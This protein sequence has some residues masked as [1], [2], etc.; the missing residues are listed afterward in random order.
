M[1]DI[2][3]N[4]E[5]AKLCPADDFLRVANDPSSIKDLGAI[6]EKGL[7]GILFPA[8]YRCSA[9]RWAADLAAAMVQKFRAQWRLEFTFGP[10]P[11]GVGRPTISTV[12]SRSLVERDTPKTDERPLWRAVF[13]NRLTKECPAGCD[14][15]V[16]Y[17]LEQRENTTARTSQVRI[18]ITIAPYNNYEHGGMPQGPS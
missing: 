6:R 17:A 12:T 15:T 7:G 13:E 3:H 2:A 16:I 5:A 10:A 14:P 11:A 4:L 8:T 1:F 9:I 18:C